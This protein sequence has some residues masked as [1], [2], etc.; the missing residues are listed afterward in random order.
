MTTPRQAIARLGKF[1][2]D[3]CPLLDQLEAATPDNV[4]TI[5]AEEQRL[6]EQIWTLGYM[7]FGTALGGAKCRTF[8]RLPHLLAAPQMCG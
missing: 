8:L 1:H 2:V 4:D 3:Y 6:A 7:A 5:V